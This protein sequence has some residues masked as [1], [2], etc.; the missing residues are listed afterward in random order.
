MK[1]NKDLAMSE[2]GFLF[3]PATGESFTVNPI[4]FEIISRLKKGEQNT[5]IIDWVCNHYFVD[6]SRVEKDLDDFF[7]LLRLHQ[8]GIEND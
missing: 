6:K 3:N 4:A 5:A 8:L 7:G 2:N 1:I